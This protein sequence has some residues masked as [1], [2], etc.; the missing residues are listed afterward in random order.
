MTNPFDLRTPEVEGYKTT[1]ASTHCF[2]PL[3]QVIRD[4]RWEFK[5]KSKKLIT[6]RGLSV[7]M[8]YPP[9]DQVLDEDAVISYINETIVKVLEALRE[10]NRL[11]PDEKLGSTD[12]TLN[13][14]YNRGYNSTMLQINLRIS[15]I[16]KSLKEME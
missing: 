11:H 15:N 4:R 13:E 9:Y 16:I 14:M 2:N 7:L 6:S 1:N 10:E 3:A 8:D 12:L 5:E